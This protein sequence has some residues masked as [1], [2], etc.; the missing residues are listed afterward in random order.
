MGRDNGLTGG[1]KVNYT[2]VG[3]IYVE[4]IGRTGNGTGGT[5][6]QFIRHD[7]PYLIR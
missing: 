6:T 2:A 3:D 1:A 7:K 4:V 5:T